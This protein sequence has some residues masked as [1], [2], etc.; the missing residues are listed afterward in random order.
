VRTLLADHEVYVTDWIDAREVPLEQGPFTLDG[1]VGYMRQFI[2]HLGAESL[3]VMSVCQPTVPVLAAAALMAAAGE[4]QPRSL[5]MI[6]GPI[7]ARRSPTVVN[8]LAT[9]KSL[10]WFDRHLIDRVPASYPGRGRRVLPGFLQHAG[11]V[12]MNPLRHVSSHW[13]FYQ[14]LVRGDLSSAEDHRRFYDEYNAVLDMPAEYYLDCVRIVFQQY[15]LPRGLWEVA[16]ERV[17]PE[18]IT[19]SALLTIE[20]ELDDISGAGQTQAAHELCTG[21]PENMRY[22]FVAAKCGH[23]GIFS[24]RRW[25]EIICPRIGEFIRKH[26]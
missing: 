10:S 8:G 11:F 25:R 4:P 2:G 6:G 21:I 23:Y 12:A 3:H 18:A 26:R 1:Y 19:R 17:A 20:G 22:D 13:D 15:L 7:D 9:T 16:G 5:T 24:G 14:H